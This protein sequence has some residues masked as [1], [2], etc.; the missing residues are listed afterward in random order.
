MNQYL[1][2]MKQ[3]LEALENHDGNYKLSS[4]QAVKHNAAIDALT[5]AIEA[6]EKA[7]ARPCGN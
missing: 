3:A 4:G 6:M 2:A 1:E 7:E 5:A